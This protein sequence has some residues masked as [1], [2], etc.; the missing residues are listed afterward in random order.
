MRRRT[1]LLGGSSL[2]AWPLPSR[3]QKMGEVRRI[4]I[5]WPNQT[6]ELDLRLRGLRLGLEELGYVE[7]R[8]IVI[9]QRAPNPEV[10]I[11]ATVQQ[12]LDAKVELILS[13]GTALT[14]AVRNLGKGIP[15]VM[16]FVSDPVGAGFVTSL[17]R[18]GGN[19]TGLTNLGPE[20][21]IKW[22]ELLREL[23]P[24]PSRLAIAHDPAVRRLVQQMRIAASAAGIELRAFEENRQQTLDEVLVA[25][26]QWRPKALVVFLPPRSAAREKRIV[27]FAADNRLPSAYWWREYVDA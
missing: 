18:P 26:K 14:H 22:L 9:A 19:I 2:I 21:S 27:Q 11:S 16:T 12:L 20:V 24:G 7:G 3:A 8:N 13:A 4:G 5:L 15:T 1:F 23:A 6:S 10:P 25:V 17:A